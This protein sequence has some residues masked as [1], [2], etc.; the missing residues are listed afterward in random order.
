MS[1]HPSLRQAGG[2][3]GA[4]RNVLKRHERVR[5]LMSHGLWTEGRSIFGLPKIKQ[6]KVK[7]RKAA[8]K[9]PAAAAAPPTGTAPPASPAS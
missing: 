2:K 5:H 4:Q 9:E 1:I 3:A 7:V 8:A 6:V